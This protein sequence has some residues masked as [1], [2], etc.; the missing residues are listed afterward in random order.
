MTIRLAFPKYS[1]TI[2]KIFSV[3]ILS[4]AI[5]SII[6]CGKAASD[7]DDGTYEV[8]IEMSGGT[9]KAYIESPAVMT[10]KDKKAEL[11][12]IWSSKNYDYM[13]VD[14]VKYLN[15]AASG[16]ASTFTIS[17]DD[18]N[19]LSEPIKVIGDTT[20]MSVPHE[21]EYT[22]LVKINE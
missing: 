2:I 13:I 14:D 15:E 17:I 18:L 9:G 6:G 16:E 8:S 21:I 1:N 20:A 4:V 11:T 12:L 22:L 10:V 5:L 3:L 19:K 7:L